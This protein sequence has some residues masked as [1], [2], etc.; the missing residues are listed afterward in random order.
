[1][2]LFQLSTNFPLSGALRFVTQEGNRFETGFGANT[3]HVQAAG[4]YILVDETG[5]LIPVSTSPAFGPFNISCQVGI[6]NATLK[7]DSG[8]A[9]EVFSSTPG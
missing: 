9:L 2:A 3:L 1:M 8:Q 7:L 4:D 6:P 5:R